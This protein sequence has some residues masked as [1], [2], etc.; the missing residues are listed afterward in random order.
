MLRLA[1]QVFASAQA[2]LSAAGRFVLGGILL[3]A[4]LTKMSR[5]FLFLSEIYDYDLV[6]RKTGFTVAILLPAIEL[7]FVLAISG[8]LLTFFRRAKE[9]L[10][11]S[12]P[13]PSSPFSSKDVLNATT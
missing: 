12:V 8:F 13:F 1:F 3:I 7:I 11:A 10:P 2:A 9:S 5:P 6:G 4:A